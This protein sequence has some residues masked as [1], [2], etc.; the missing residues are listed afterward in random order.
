MKW[1][2]I[3]IALLMLQSFSAGAVTEC[4]VMPNSLY[5]GDDGALWVTFSNG[6]SAYMYATD[7]DFKQT[8]ALIQ[9]PILADK[10]LTVRYAADGLSCTSTQLIAGMWLLR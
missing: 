7:P 2:S 9:S 6:G 10:Y 5:A 4:P 1:K 3:L 8:F